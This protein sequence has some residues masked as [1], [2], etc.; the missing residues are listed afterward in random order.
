MARL[1][2]LLAGTV[3]TRGQHS[4]VRGL[5][6][7]PGEYGPDLPPGWTEGPAGSMPPQPAFDP[8]TLA[9]G[10]GPITGEVPGRSSRPPSAPGGP[11]TAG[12]AV[13]PEGALTGKILG[14]PWWVL[15]LG[16]GAFFYFKSQKR[17][18]S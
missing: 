8:E 16:V 4:G 13:F 2:R 15:A 11:T 1:Q 18:R 3:Y 9:A 7:A 17:R 10:I 12:V 14:V 5:G 6:L